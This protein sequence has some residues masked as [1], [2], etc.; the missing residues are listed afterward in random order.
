MAQGASSPAMT[1]TEIWMADSSPTKL[2]SFAFASTA[3]ILF[4]HFA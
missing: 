4:R 3:L 1:T 2:H